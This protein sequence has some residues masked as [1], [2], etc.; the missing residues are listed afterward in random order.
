MANL[1]KPIGSTTVLT[2]AVANAELVP[3][4]GDMVTWSSTVGTVLVDPVNSQSAT[5]V[6]SVL[7][8]VSFTATTSNGITSAAVDVDYVDNTPASVVVTAS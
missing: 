2:A 7:G 5:F 4:P 8:T 1:Q 3:L 6:G